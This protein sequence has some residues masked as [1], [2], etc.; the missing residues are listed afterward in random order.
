MAR[1]AE[2]DYRN[3]L[4]V[5]RA[6]GDVS[7]PVPFPETVLDALRRLIPCDVV[8]YHERSASRRRRLPVYIGEPRG[9]LTPEIRNAHRR[10]E[11]ED[12]FRPA[13]GARK[14][15][16]FVSRRNYQRRELYQRVDRPLGIEYM[17]QLYIEP[18]AGGSRVEFDR[19]D[20]DFDERDRGVLDLLLPH[21][22]QSV[23]AAARRRL[24][25]PPATEVGR[26]T[27]RERE[28]LEQVAE[29]RTNAEV[30]WLLRIS[31]DTVRKHL[32]N[33]YEKL[34]VHSRTGAVA[35]LRRQVDP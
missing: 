34:G 28:I 24:L 35:M 12:P 2:S 16:D 25:A 7:G 26:L 3:V 14:L 8:T 23:V 30:A 20:S 1:L 22:R 33:T 4:E 11:H 27:P 21:L 10:L 32:E 29:G 5:L 19:F 18:H 6:A 31:P 17:L 9:P 13:D 15:T